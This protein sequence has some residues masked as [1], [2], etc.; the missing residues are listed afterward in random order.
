LPLHPDFIR[1]VDT[2]NNVIARTIEGITAIVGSVERVP[3][4]PDGKDLQNVALVM[5]EGGIVGRQAKTL[6][7]MY[8]VFHEPR[9][10]TPAAAAEPVTIKGR[11]VGIQICEDMWDADYGRKVTKE[12]VR[13]GRGTGLPGYH[14]RCVSHEN[15]LHDLDAGRR[16]LSQARVRPERAELLDAMVGREVKMA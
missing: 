13:A 12:L 11:K 6:L 15:R 7:P 2:A 1:D 14:G 4:G 5:T 3:R 16:G 8:D 10:F 9:Y